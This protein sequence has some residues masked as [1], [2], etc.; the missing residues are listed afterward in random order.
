[1]LI[2]FI[3]EVEKADE[4]VAHNG[5]RYDIKWLRTRC[6]KH[7]IFIPDKIDTFDTLK[8]ARKQFNFNSNKLDYI[9]KFF[10]FKGKTNTGGFQ[11][12]VD[13]LNGSEKALNKMVKYCENDVVILEKVFNK[14]YKYSEVNQHTGVNFGEHRWSCVKCGSQKI[15]SNGTRTTKS[16]TTSHRMRCRSCGGGWTV[17]SAVYKNYLTWQYDK[18]NKKKDSE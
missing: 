4:C 7:N 5:D 8:K 13:V 6:A 17:S 3:K 15:R 2:D 11:L 9:A 16:G 1:M 14:I 10:G 12:W 18:K